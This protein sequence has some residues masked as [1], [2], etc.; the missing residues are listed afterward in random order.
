M[1]NISNYKQKRLLEIYTNPYI[2]EFIENHGF[3]ND[4]VSDNFVVFDECLSSLELCNKCS[5]IDNCKQGKK[6]EIVGLSYDGVVSNSCVYCKHYLFIDKLQELRNSFVYS[7]IPLF[8]YDLSLDNITL[9]ENELKD[10]FGLCYNIFNGETNKGLYIFGKLGV[11]KTYMCIALANSLVKKGKKVAFIKVNDFVTKMS[12]LIRE[13]VVEFER[14]LNLI[15]KA[16]YL[17]I[18]DIGSEMV[19]EFSRD[20]LLFNILDYRMENKLCTFFT[21][22]LD[23]KLLLKHFESEKDSLKAERLLERI[24]VLSENYCL[25]GINKRRVSQ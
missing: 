5:G 15:K 21:S 16:E 18:D 23:K 10:L 2:K 22:N 25:K 3:S 17:F 6:G 13:D 8:R 1:A 14:L 9:D 11:G 19:S 24:E 12:E 20:R 4:Y 7:D